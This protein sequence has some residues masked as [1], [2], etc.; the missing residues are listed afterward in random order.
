G[1]HH[2]KE[3][4]EPLAYEATSCEKVECRP[5][6]A[7]CLVCPDPSGPRRLPHVASPAGRRN[8]QANL[9]RP[10]PRSDCIVL[11]GVCIG[12]AGN[13]THDSLSPGTQE[14]ERPTLG[15]LSVSLVSFKGR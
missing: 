9:F 2:P 7:R 13:Q 12:V 3:R 15:T 4:L 6:A 5:A 10:H 14:K 1:P 8:L 11:R